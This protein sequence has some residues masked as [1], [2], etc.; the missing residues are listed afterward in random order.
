MITS[1]GKKIERF[2][3]GLTPP[4]EGNVIAANPET[5]DSAKRLAKKLYEHNNKKGEKAGE[6]ESKKEN[7]NKKG[8]NNNRK[9]RQGSESSKK[10]QLVTVHA[11]TT[12]VPSTPHA[13]ASSTPCAPKQYSGYLPKCNKCNLHHN[14]ECREM[15]C[16][17]CNRKGHTAKYCRTYPPQNQQQG[18]NNN[19][20]NNKTP[21]T[22][23]AAT[24]GLATPVMDVEGL[25]T[26]VENAPMSTTKGMEEQ[27]ECRPWVKE[28]RFR[29][30]LFS[31]V[32]F[33]LTAHM[34][35]SCLIPGQSGVL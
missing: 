8:K 24:M 33:S 32:R 12:Q 31:L 14:G 1:E 18:N 16:T 4:I 23:T 13:P 22:T 34:H 3:W 26:S 19:N 2:I 28:K 7:D 21:T 35:A 5:F 30:P 27:G 9:G 15:Q 11:A 17:S 20:R 6:T 29:I 25:G 10:Q